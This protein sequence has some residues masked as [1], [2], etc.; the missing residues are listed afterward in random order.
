MNISLSQSIILKQYILYFK[1]K[2]RAERA[3][4]IGISARSLTQ[5][6]NTVVEACQGRLVFVSRC[7][8][9]R[10][11]QEEKNASSSLFKRLI[12]WN[13]RSNASTIERQESDSNISLSYKE[14]C[15]CL[16]LNPEN[17]YNNNINDIKNNK[18]HNILNMAA[19]LTG[20]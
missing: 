7:T 9:Q 2:L 3:M 6:C 12:Q 1:Q 16:G 15:L 17:K 10:L 8:F 20:N 13:V 5:K 11:T 14:L 18:K 19:K 4:K